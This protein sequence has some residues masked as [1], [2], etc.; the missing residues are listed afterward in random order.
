MDVGRRSQPRFE[1]GIRTVVADAFKAYNMN[2]CKV[3]SFTH[4]RLREVEGGQSSE[5]WYEISVADVAVGT[6]S[7]TST[8]GISVPESST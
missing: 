1:G 8:R 2:M 4:E 5:L 6:S 7:L 3:C